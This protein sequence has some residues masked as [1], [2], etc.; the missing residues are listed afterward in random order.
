MRNFEG[1]KTI[2]QKYLFSVSLQIKASQGVLCGQSNVMLTGQGSAAQHTP[3]P[4]QGSPT[5]GFFGELR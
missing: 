1:F 5:L 4:L 2:P 3:Q